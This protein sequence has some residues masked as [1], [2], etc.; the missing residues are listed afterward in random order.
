MRRGRSVEWE[1]ETDG[2]V[3]LGPGT[4]YGLL[5]IVL[6]NGMYMPVEGREDGVHTWGHR[7]TH[8]ADARTFLSGVQAVRQE[9]S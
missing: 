2:E 7:F 5:V 9:K 3:G 1:E 4:V 6:E 8:E